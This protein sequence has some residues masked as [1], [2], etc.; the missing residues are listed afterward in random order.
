MN[1]T[2]RLL[3]FFAA[4]LL[5][6]SPL[7]ANAQGPRGGD[8]PGGGGHEQRGQGGREHHGGRQG[9]PQRDGYN[10]QDNRNSFRD[11]RGPQGGPQFDQR[12][13]N[14][15]NNGYADRGPN[16]G[17]NYDQRGPNRGHNGYVDRGPNH[18]SN[19]PPMVAP[20]PPRNNG[21]GNGYAHRPHRGP[22]PGW[23]RHHNYN[24]QRHVY[25]PDYYTY[26]D[27]YRGGYTYWY[28]N[29]W[30]FSQALPQFLM[31]VDLGRARI[32]MIGD[33]PVTTGPERY[34][35][36]YAR[37]YPPTIQIRIAPRPPLP[38]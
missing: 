18:G 24:F 3:G 35:Q 28:N 34:Y 32:Q 4:G 26:Y 36:R 27:P 30:M 31:G 21:Y 16:R 37:R 10:R 13:P 14:G 1:Y 33:I 6:A 2:N 12:G 17:P 7:L 19:R 22:M 5:L 38:W 9:G 23:A 11:N 15:R 8:R 25:F 20:R 29:S